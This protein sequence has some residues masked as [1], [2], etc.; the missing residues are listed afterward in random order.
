[1]MLYISNKALINSF[2]LTKFKVNKKVVLIPAII[3]SFVSNII[4]YN[5]LQTSYLALVAP[6]IMFT[7]VLIVNEI[8]NYENKKRINI[9]KTTSLGLL[10]GER[11]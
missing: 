11:K 2:D 8:Y 9:I 1:M 3:S 5:D 6:L 4:R 10:K 7:G